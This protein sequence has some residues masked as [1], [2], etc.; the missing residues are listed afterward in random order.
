LEVNVSFVDPHAVRPYQQST[1]ALAHFNPQ[2]VV[3]EVLAQN[4]QMVSELLRQYSPQLATDAGAGVAAYNPQQTVL[5]DRGRTSRYKWTVGAIVGIC[6]IVALGLGVAIYRAGGDSIVATAAFLL[7]WGGMALY[8]ANRAQ[9]TDAEHSPDGVS[10]V[11]ERA[12]AYSVETDAESR[13]ALA[14]AYADSI[15][16]AAQ[17]DAVARRMAARQQQQRIDADLL[18][19]Q[20]ATRRPVERPVSDLSTDLSLPV[21]T[22]VATCQP[23][24]ADDAIMPPTIAAI[25]LAWLD[26]GMR[27]GEIQPGRPLRMRAPW[28]ARGELPASVKPEV[29]RRLATCQPPLFTDGAGNQLVFGPYSANAARAVVRGVLSDL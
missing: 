6:G 23:P 9:Y 10:L 4:G 16:I 27:S 8:Y 28:S 29:A 26:A 25:V 22:P 1:T 5:D 2:A 14:K 19:L 3:S 17:A 21:A 11:V 15:T 24:A 13:Q 12:R 18:R 7:S 20:A